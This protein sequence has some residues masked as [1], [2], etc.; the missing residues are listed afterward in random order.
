MILVDAE[1]KPFA[2][3]IRIL[4]QGNYGAATGLITMAALVGK[5]TFPQM[6]LLIMLEMIFYTL[7]RTIITGV[8][9]AVDAAGSM[10][11]HMF[12]AYFG[13]TCAFYF[14]PRRAITDEFE[15]GKHNYNSRLIAMIGTLFLFVYFPSFNSALATGVA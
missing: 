15:Q 6:Y 8:M 9:M 14:K 1:F 7:N 5:T 12:G 13:L 4:I 11:I 10:T 2:I 3:D